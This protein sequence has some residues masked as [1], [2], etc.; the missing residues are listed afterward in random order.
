M[1][2]LLRQHLSAIRKHWL[3]GNSVCCRLTS[4][5]PPRLASTWPEVLSLAPAGPAVSLDDLR[6]WIK[7]TSPMV[8]QIRPALGTNDHNYEQLVQ[9]LKKKNY[10]SCR[11]CPPV[12]TSS[13]LLDSMPFRGGR[14]QEWDGPR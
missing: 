12:K 7:T 1:R 9:L 3:P 5:Y 13:Y 4:T 6:D 11:R 10:V 8:V 14:S 2:R